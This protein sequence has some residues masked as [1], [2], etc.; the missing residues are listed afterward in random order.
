MLRGLADVGGTFADG[1]AP[2]DALDDTIADLAALAGLWAE[3]TVHGPAWRFGEIGRRVE[4]AL[5][6][7]GLVDACLRPPDRRPERAG[8]PVPASHAADIV[9]AS[10]M[11]VLLAANE[12]LVAYR[13]RHRSDIELDAAVGLLLRD[14]DN[15]RSYAA[16]VAHLAEHVRVVGWDEGTA[17]VDAL[18]TLLDGDDPLADLVTAHEAVCAVAQLTIDTWFATPVNPILVHATPG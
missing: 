18:R 13:R 17:A 6:V 12:S 2:I 15:P 5:V 7:L 4:R 9:E 10:A 8:A 11:E 14:A 3:S 1:R 16:S